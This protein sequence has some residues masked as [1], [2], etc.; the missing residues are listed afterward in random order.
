[1]I[2]HGNLPKD[3]RSDAGLIKTISAFGI[4]GMV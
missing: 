2:N 1:M 4:V 3:V